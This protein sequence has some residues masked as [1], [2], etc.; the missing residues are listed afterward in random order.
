MTIDFPDNPYVGQVYTYGNA[1]WKWDGI[2]W[3]RI[4]DPGAKGEGGDLSLIHI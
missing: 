4:P 1:S 2:A 3:R